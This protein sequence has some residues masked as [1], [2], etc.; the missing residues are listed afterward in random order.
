MPFMIKKLLI[1]L[2]PLCLL[3]CS[4]GQPSHSPEV[5]DAINP[6]KAWHTA[7]DKAQGMQIPFEANN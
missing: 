6:L 1:Y 4:Q 2:L 3:A 5:Q 7:C